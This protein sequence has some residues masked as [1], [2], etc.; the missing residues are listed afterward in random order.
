MVAPLL[1]TT[2][3]ANTKSSVLRP[4]KEHY[5][6]ALVQIRVQE[7]KFVTFNIKTL[8]KPALWGALVAVAACYVLSYF[9]DIGSIPV[10]TGVLSGR[11]NLGLLGQTPLLHAAV[12]GAIAGVV[13]SLIPLPPMRVRN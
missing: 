6:L 11:L 7:T 1:N 13:A 3:T 9:P 2:N 8:L 12:F 4:L 5:D 10:P